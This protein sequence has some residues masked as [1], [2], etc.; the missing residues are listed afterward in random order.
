MET[1]AAVAAPENPL[2]NTSVHSIRFRHPGYPPQ[3]DLLLTLSAYDHLEGGLYHQTA[4]DAL[5]VVTGN[6]PGGYLTSTLDGS[7]ITFPPHRLLRLK[8]YWYHLPPPPATT[9]EVAE[10]GNSSG[11]PQQA[12][13][14]IASSS[15]LEKIR[16]R[17]SSCRVSAYRSATEAAHIIPRQ[18]QLWFTENNMDVFNTNRNLTGTYIMDDMANGIML[19]RDIHFVFDSKEFVFVPK[20]NKIVTH[21]LGQS[22]D[23]GILYHNHATQPLKDTSKEF[24][25]ARFAYSV[26]PLLLKFLI[27][28]PNR[29]IQRTP[30]PN[31]VGYSAE[32]A[33]QHEFLA[34][35][36]STRT[37]SSPQKRHRGSNQASDDLSSPPSF[38]R[39]R[40]GRQDSFSA[41]SLSPSPTQ[42][43][44][45]PDDCGLELHQSLE[46]PAVNSWLTSQL[47]TGAEMVEVKDVEAPLK[48]PGLEEMYRDKQGEEYGEDDDRNVWDT[49]QL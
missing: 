18:M 6:M 22:E 26:F 35:R 44:E 34:S 24:L 12:A 32:W 42:K 1:S 10:D 8:D 3:S 16:S 37:N 11:I 40:L 49:E 47:Q 13:Q 30:Q 5:S 14:D 20:N 25:Y 27:R 45:P 4:L 21:F 38:K 19:R 7:P 28:G 17:D 43:S 39:R 31:G 36:P 15:F 23:L 2:V 46:Y 33:T 41:A 29:F 48:G 9:G